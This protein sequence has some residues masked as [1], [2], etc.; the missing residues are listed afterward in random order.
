MA[1][2]RDHDRVS[3]LDATEV[4]GKYLLCAFTSQRDGPHGSLQTPGEGHRGLMLRKKQTRTG[5]RVDQRPQQR[6]IDKRVAVHDIKSTQPRCAQPLHGVH[7]RR[8]P[9]LPHRGDR[10]AAM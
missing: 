1:G 4:G 7:E 10:R 2:G 3:R 8:C 9:G 5:E 6:T